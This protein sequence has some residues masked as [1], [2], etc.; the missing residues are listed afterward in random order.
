MY[1]KS[2]F[3]LLFISLAGLTIYNTAFVHAEDAADAAYRKNEIVAMVNQLPAKQQQ[4]DSKVYTGTIDQIIAYR[5]ADVNEVVVFSELIDKKTE[6]LCKDLKM[7]VPEKEF[8]KE[9][10]KKYNDTIEVAEKKHNNEF[11]Q[12]VISMRNDPN[13]IPESSDPNYLTKIEQ[14]NSFMIA[15]FELAKPL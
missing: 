12:A 10:I 8:F 9:L 13:V 14:W 11:L 5:I 3:V 6:S 1:K 15:C 4:L 7:S 2:L